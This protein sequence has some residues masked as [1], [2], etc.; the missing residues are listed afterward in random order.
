MTGKSRG[1][2]D[3]FGIDSARQAFAFLR[4]L[5]L[6]S[7]VPYGLRR[8]P[9]KARRWPVRR[10]PLRRG[11]RSHV[12]DAGAP[13]EVAV[14]RLIFDLYVNGARNRTQICN[15]LNAG[16]IAPP[17]R[18]A[19]WSCRA[20]ERILA[21]PAYIGANEFRG[22]TQQDVF[23]ALIEKP[24]YYQAKARLMIEGSP[25]ALRPG[26]TGSACP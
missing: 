26:R 12:L 3:R 9:R 6:P 17:G 20:V 19:A 11:R 22:L 4:G 15:L 13:E 10:G 7:F 1:P 14:V 21:N 25:R 5:Y 18:C 2:F 16:R 23:P 8:V 24:I